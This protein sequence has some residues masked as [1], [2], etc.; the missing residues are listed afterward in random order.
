MGSFGT[1]LAIMFSIVI[2]SYIAQQY[3][4]VIITGTTEGETIFTY[5]VPAIIVVAGIA[6]IFMVWFRPK[7]TKEV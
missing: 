1:G 5:L 3:I 4:P 6:A 2:V 7:R